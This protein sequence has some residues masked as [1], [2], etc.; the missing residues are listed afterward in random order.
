MHKRMLFLTV[1]T[2]FFSMQSVFGQDTYFQ[3][4]NKEIELMAI[5]LTEDYQP[6]LVMTSDQTLLFEKKVGEFLIREKKIK[7]R[8][9]LTIRQ[10]MRLLARLSRQETAEMRNILTRPQFRRYKE[11]KKKIQPV[12]MSVGRV[13]KK[14]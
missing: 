9:D 1:F 6:E 7:S 2:I 8:Q 13:S 4:G 11:V 5:A 14:D 3:E 12:V 10:R